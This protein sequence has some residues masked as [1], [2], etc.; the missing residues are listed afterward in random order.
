M[1]VE[2]VSNLMTDGLRLPQDE[3]AHAMPAVERNEHGHV[4]LAEAF[5]DR[6][7]YLVRD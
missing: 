4:R 7:G 5:R 6:Y 2:L 3:L 1:D